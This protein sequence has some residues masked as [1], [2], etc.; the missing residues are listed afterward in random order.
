M[1]HFLNDYSES[2]HPDIIAALHDSHKQQHKG[3][4]FDEFSEKVRNSIK[5]KIGNP[6]IA[7]HFGITGTQ[8]NLVCIDAMLASID[9]IIACDTGHIA[10]NEAGAIEATGHKVIIAPSTNGKLT[11]DALEKVRLRHSFAPHVVRSRAVYISNTTEL[12]TVYNYDE[13]KAIS[14]YCR[15]HD[16]YLFMDGARLGA[17]IASSHDD[18]NQRNLTLADFAELTDIFWFGGTKMGAMFGEILII[19][20]Q[21]IAK[22][23]NIYLKQHGGLLAKGY[24]MALQFDVLLKNDKYLE[25][26]R[27]ANTM[28]RQ[29]SQSLVDAGHKLFVATES[30]Q[31]FAV[32][33]QT[34]IQFLKTKF[35]FYEWEVLNDEFSIVRLVTSWATDPKQVTRFVEMVKE[36]AK[37]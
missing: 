21:K 31:V 1:Y 12:G 34:L 13:L 14:D 30:N 27:H 15:E 26:C 36:Q 7:V 37:I 19:P 9:G 18:P 23:F 2:A 3:Y 32:L 28:A 6:D 4:G 8:A 16:M 25:L 24:L 11:I 22:D 10:V 17:A 33:P 29:I 5:Q 20:N 35:E